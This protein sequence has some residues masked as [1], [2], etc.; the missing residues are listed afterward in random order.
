MRGRLF[1]AV[2]TITS[3]LA[4]CGASSPDGGT[5][6][7]LVDHTLDEF[8]TSFFGYFPRVTEAHPGDTIE[9]DQTWTGEP[10]TITFGT[11]VEPLGDILRPLLTKAKA[12]PDYIDTSEYGLPS[13]FSD[14]PGDA[15][16]NQIAA[17]PCYLDA[18]P[19]PADAKGCPK[20]QPVFDGTQAF[21]NS[22]YIPYLGAKKNRY[23]VPLAPTIKPGHYFY[24][25]VLHG[26]GMGGFVDVKPAGTT[27]RS[28]EGL[29]DA[30]LVRA[31]ATA[32]RARAQASHASFRLPGTDI[33][34]GTFAPFTKGGQS[35]PVSVNEFLP[36]T[37]HTKVGVPVT[38]SFIA[39]PGHTVSFDVPSYLPAIRFTKSGTVKVNEDT[40][41]P[42]GGPGYPGGDAPT[43]GFR[44]DV[45]N[46]DGG[47]FL[48]SGYPDGAMRYSITFTKPGTYPYACL[49]HPLMLGRIVVNA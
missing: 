18:G 22:G 8:A 20:K 43:D 28:S 16:I 4:A 49:I 46:Y 44:V 29:H 15:S 23:D 47:H 48:S 38:W 34:A 5:R 26:P 13:V 41:F 30:D 42:V 12:L 19:L 36:S 9:F 21:Y 1:V 11:M 17:Q 27:L 24:Y 45:G 2:A 35:D 6:R 40:L 25:C 10:H 39:G 7:V 33:Q 14:K 37:F 31:V 32:R 3:M